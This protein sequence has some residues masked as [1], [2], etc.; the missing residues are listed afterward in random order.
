MK[1]LLLFLVSFSAFAQYPVSDRNLEKIRNTFYD[2]T[3]LSDEKM[4]KYKK[5]LK[6]LQKQ[7]KANIENYETNLNELDAAA[8]TDLAK[9]NKYVQNL[10]RLRVNWVDEIYNITDPVKQ[11]EHLTKVIDLETAIK[12]EITPINDESHILKGVNQFLENYKIPFKTPKEFGEASNLLDPKTG[13]YLSQIKLQNLIKSGYDISLLNPPSDNGVIEYIEDISQ[14]DTYKRYR[15][16]QNEMHKGLKVEFPTKHVGFF[17]E[18]R[19]T[20]SRPKIIFE[21]RDESGQKTGE[22][23]LKMGMEIHSEPTVA[24]LGVTLGL[25]HDL[26]KYVENFKIYIGDTTY[27]EFVLNFSSYF[28]YEDLARIV[29]EHGTDQQHG[30]YIVFHEG[31]LEAKFKSKQLRRVGPFYP[32]YKKGKRE[33]RALMLFN[34]WTHNPDLKPG[35]NNKTLIRTING[36]KKVYYMQHDVGYSIGKYGREKPTEFEWDIVK[37]VNK[38][39]IIFDYRS[40]VPHDGWD[41][42]SYF[43]AKWMVRKIAQLTRHQITTAVKLGGWPTV[44]PYNFEE[45]IIEKLINRRNDLVKTFK[46]IGEKHPS[47]QSISMMPVYKE[48]ENQ[49]KVPTTFLPGETIDFRPSIQYIF[50]YPALRAIRDGIVNGVAAVSRSLD[51][52]NLS[53]WIGLDNGGVIVQALLGTEKEIIQNPNPKHLGERFIVKET[54]RMGARLGAGSIFTGDTSYVKKYTLIYGVEDKEK[55]NDHGKWVVDVTMPYRIMKNY[56]PKN[57][58]LIS[59]TFLEGRGRVRIEVPYFGPGNEAALKRVN[60]ARTV[61]SKKPKEPV[62][63]YIDTSNYTTLL[64]NVYTK[65]GLVRLKHFTINTTSGNLNRSVYLMNDDVNGERAIDSAIMNNDPSLLSQF[66]KTQEVDSEFTKDESKYSIFGF[67]KGSTEY[68]EDNLKIYSFSEDGKMIQVN[69]QLEGSYEKNSSWRFITNGEER[70]TRVT[71]SSIINEDSMIASPYIN[72]KFKHEDKDTT[73]AEIDD[74]YIPFI[75][76]VANDENF[77]KFSARKHSV[78]GRYGHL[79]IHL[80]ERIYENGIEKLL[81]TNE[82]SFWKSFNHV[83]GTKGLI[84]DKAYFKSTKPSHGSVVKPKRQYISFQGKRYVKRNLIRKA[85]RTFNNIRKA[86]THLKQKLKIKSLTQALGESIP[87][88]S[89]SQNSIILATIN[90]LIGKANYYLMAYIESPSYEENK[91]PGRI[92]PFA[93]KGV[94]K[95]SQ[96]RELIKLEMKDALDMYKNF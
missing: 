32:G 4:S 27:E 28:I 84:G 96:D 1:V 31:M 85:K 5:H 56:L 93:A 2:G 18:L 29:K 9:D 57:H 42:V 92:T 3:D 81:A 45:L 25:F 66:S 65:L 91:M 35:E 48:I 40:A 8:A 53:E 87:G 11:I 77:L 20:Q 61:L 64:D 79:N 54:F 41:H 19:K 71:M 16:G 17:K 26:S 69:H 74:H 36:E 88:K 76:G 59:E 22:F 47:G 86:Q 89:H 37:E 73:A 72:I 94:M 7:I 6:K 55:V 10:K 52:V 90:H 63:I 60:L 14:V 68:R 33:T 24:S 70:K 78:T 23:K 39:E 46:L 30:N 75:N 49:V 95:T 38:D 62:K 43:D 44:E 83:L 51:K 82:K 50:L 13:K 21:T 34:L 80:Q 58:I 67:F 12:V 15:E